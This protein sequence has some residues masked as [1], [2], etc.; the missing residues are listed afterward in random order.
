MNV[1]NELRKLFLSKGLSTKFNSA[2]TWFKTEKRT[3]KMCLV[4]V[5][6]TECSALLHTG[7]VSILNLVRLLSHMG[8]DP[9]PT[10]RT[11][12][13]SNGVNVVCKQ[14][15]K[16]VPVMFSGEA[17]NLDFLAVD[18]VPVDL[19]IGLINLDLLQATLNLGRQFVDFTINKQSIRIV[20]RPETD[21]QDDSRG[22]M[23]TEILIQI[24]K[25]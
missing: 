21:E 24:P 9:S 1:Q 8:I 13:V 3:L 5:Y 25:S 20:L 23:Q 16:R 17:T 7:A 14:I 18:E 11:I 2:N 15:G 12:T 22:R 4:R 6:G 10:R 19:L